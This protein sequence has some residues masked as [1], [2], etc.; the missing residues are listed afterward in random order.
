MGLA[1]KISTTSL[2][3]K[4]KSLYSFEQQFKK[5]LNRFFDNA[6]YNGHQSKK[7]PGIINVS[8]PNFQSDKVMVQLDRKNI[9]I[10]NGSACGSGNIEPSKVLSAIGLNEKINL[11]TLRFSFGKSNDKQQIDYLLSSLE[12]ILVKS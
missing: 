8:F 6:I 12:S 4:I 10:S 3:E 1:A 9:A 2:N 11:S 7:L 5:G